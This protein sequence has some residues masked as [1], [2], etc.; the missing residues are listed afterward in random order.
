MGPPE[1]AGRYATGKVIDMGARGMD[2]CWTIM[3]EQA[4]EIL[5]YSFKDKR[6]LNK[7]LTH[8]SIAG[9]RLESNERM[10]FLGDAILGYIVCEYLFQEFP[11]FHEGEMT[12]IK[13]AVVSRRICAKISEQINLNSMLSLGKG[14]ISHRVLPSNVSAA[15]LEAIVA[16]IYMDGGIEEARRFILENMKPFIHEAA[17][18]THQQNFKSVLQQYAQRGM[19]RNPS[20]H[21]LD[22]KGPDHAKCFEVCVELNGRQFSSAWANVKKEAE[23]RA[24]LLALQELDLVTVDDDGNVVLDASIVPHADGEQEASPTTSDRHK[25]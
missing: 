17:Q 13:S 4:V 24:A 19:Q 7:A 1:I 3:S 10:E 8:A 11:T 6:L 18:S 25:G 2:T 20:Y 9:H 14:M 22:E 23:Q 15:V 16:A 12:K 21:L 5:G